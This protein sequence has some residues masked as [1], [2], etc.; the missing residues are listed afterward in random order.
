MVF[1]IILL[2]FFVSNKRIKIIT[3]LLIIFCLGYISF[4]IFRYL[5]DNYQNNKSIEL[6]IDEKI[7]DKVA[8]KYRYKYLLEIPS[9]GLKRGVLDIDNE[10]NSANYN[11]ELLSI[12]NDSVILASH[13]GN[14]YNSYFGKLNKLELGDSINYY[15]DGKI[16]TYIYSDSYEIKKNG[17]ADIYQDE[18]KKSII[19]ITCKDNSSDGQVV[20]I[21]YL[22]EIKSY[23][24][25]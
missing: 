2:I 5:N 11:I 21:G 23:K 7:N 12:N 15:Y 25:E 18:N 22:K 3:I 9:I 13:N 14:N 4:Q 8:L 16:Y 1:S 17:Y 19:L 10:Y 6:F 20:Y 24:G